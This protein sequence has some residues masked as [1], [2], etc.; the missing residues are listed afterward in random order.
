[1]SWARALCRMGE[2]RALGGERVLS[3][4]WVSVV[5]VFCVDGRV[6]SDGSTCGVSLSQ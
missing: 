2:C 4:V 3:R 1:M 6:D 5:S